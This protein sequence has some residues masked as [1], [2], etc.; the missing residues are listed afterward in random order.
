MTVA[1]VPDRYGECADCDSPEGDI[2]CRAC[3]EDEMIVRL[4]G[5][6]LREKTK[7]PGLTHSE[8]SLIERLISDM[9]AP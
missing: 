3:S 8:V 2:I 1:N 5:W 7:F 6:L 9:E 4:R